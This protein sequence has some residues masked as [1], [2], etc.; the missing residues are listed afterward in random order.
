MKDGKKLPNPVEVLLRNF[1][2]KIYVSMVKIAE[3][4]RH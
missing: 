4:T 3:I 1:H 2:V